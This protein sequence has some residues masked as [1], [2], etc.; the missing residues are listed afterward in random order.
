MSERKFDN[1]GMIYKN[2]QKERD[3]HPDYKGKITVDGRDYWLSGWVKEGQRGKFISLAVKPQD[4]APSRPARSAPAP[5]GSDL[6]DEIP[7]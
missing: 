4:E 3:N 6:D 5:K 1:S 7:F 2:D